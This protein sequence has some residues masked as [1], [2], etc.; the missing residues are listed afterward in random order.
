MEHQEFAQLLGSYGEF[1]A[2]IAVVAALVY[3]AVQIRQNTESLRVLPQGAFVGEVLASQD[4]NPPGSSPES[5]GG[6]VVE[7]KVRSHR[8]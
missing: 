1:V 2:A 5:G 6:S 7:S 4:T 3:R 8:R